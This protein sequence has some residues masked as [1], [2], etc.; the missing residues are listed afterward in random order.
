MKQ[1]NY[2][3]FTYRPR[4]GTEYFVIGNNPYTYNIESRIVYKTSGVAN[5]LVPTNRTTG[6]YKSYKDAEL[7]LEIAREAI[8]KNVKE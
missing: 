8:L 6:N 1:F 2:N 4:M 5:S 7:A 3:P